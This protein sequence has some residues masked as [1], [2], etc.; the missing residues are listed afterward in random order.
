MCVRERGGGL[1]EA[2]DT[3]TGACVVILRGCKSRHIA[4]TTPIFPGVPVLENLVS[5]EE[6]PVCGA[7][8][9]ILWIAEPGDGAPVCR[10]CAKIAKKR[11]WV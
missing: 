2:A 8:S 7:K 1:D 9:M 4:E 6:H 3:M 11:G 10:K 5:M